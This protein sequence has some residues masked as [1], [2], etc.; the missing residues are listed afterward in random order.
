MYKCS[1]PLVSVL[2]SKMCVHCCQ[3]F[4]VSPILN[5]RGGTI[6][7]PFAAAVLASTIISKGSISTL[8]FFNALRAIC[9]FSATTSAI[10]I[11]QK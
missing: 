5:F 6:N 10:G 11:P 9:S 1:C 7:S 4:S 3:K 8:I 2:P